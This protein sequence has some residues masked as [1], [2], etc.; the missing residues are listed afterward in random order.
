VLFIDE[1]YSLARGGMN[2]FGAEALD[3]MVKAM[4][5]YRDKL[6]VILAG[7]TQEMQALFAMNPGLE[8]RVAFTCEFPDYTPE[9]LLEIARLEAKKQGFSLASEAESALFKHFKRVDIGS[10]GNGRYARKLI[11]S[12]ARKAVLAERDSE[13]RPED[14]A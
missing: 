11:E 2:D 4:E 9:E 13:I 12:A 3:T 1:A 8:S 5:D 14:F 7:Y 10:R 6:V